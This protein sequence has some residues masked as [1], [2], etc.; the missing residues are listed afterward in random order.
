[1]EAGQVLFIRLEPAGMDEQRKMDREYLM[2]Y[3]GPGFFAF[4]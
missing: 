1:M 2:Y 4:V 3:R